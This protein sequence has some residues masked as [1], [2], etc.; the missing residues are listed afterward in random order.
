MVG[1]IYVNMMLY[2]SNG[3]ASGFVHWYD[4]LHSILL[5]EQKRESHYLSLKTITYEEMTADIY[6]PSQVATDI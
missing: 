6:L 2:L 4:D 5:Q 1:E 3:A